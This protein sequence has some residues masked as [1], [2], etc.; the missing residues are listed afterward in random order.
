[1]YKR[2]VDKEP[3]MS[4]RKVPAGPETNVVKIGLDPKSSVLEM[5]AGFVQ[6]PKFSDGVERSEQYR[7][8]DR[9][10]WKGEND[11]N[12]LC[13]RDAEFPFSD[14][15]GTGFSGVGKRATFGRRG[16]ARQG[17]M[18]GGSGS[19]ERAWQEVA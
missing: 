19:K 18:P 12:C 11:R 17:G 1:M 9:G 6:D 3:D 2:E 15:E 10:G 5:C 13:L 4:P 16:A 14:E 7:K 8:L